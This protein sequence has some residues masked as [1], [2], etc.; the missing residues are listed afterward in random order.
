MHNQLTLR[1]FLI[2]S[3]G[4]LTLVGGCLKKDKLHLEGIREDLHLT[5]HQNIEAE[6]IKQ[7]PVLLPAESEQSTWANPGGGSG[8][9]YAHHRLNTPL[10]LKWKVKLDGNATESRSLTLPVTDGQ[11]LYALTGMGQVVKIMKTT[12]QKIW[13]KNISVDGTPLAT[14]GGGLCLS[15]EFILVSTAMGDALCLNKKTGEILW[16]RAL[17]APARGQPFCTGDKAFFLTVNNHLE[18][19]NIDTGTPLWAHAGIL[20]S[21]S[22]LGAGAVQLSRGNVIVPY[23]SGEVFSIDQESGQAQWVQSLSSITSL[24]EM[25]RLSQVKAQPI[26]DNQHIYLTSNGGIFMAVDKE[27]GYVVWQRDFGSAHTPAQ[28]MNVLFAITTDERLICVHKKT[29]K[30]KWIRP[31]AHPQAQLDDAPEDIETMN[32]STEKA[33]TL[34]WSSPM[35]AGGKLLV[36]S[37]DGTILFINPTTGR[38]KDTLKLPSALPIGGII[39]ENNLYVATQTG[40]L[41]A[42]AGTS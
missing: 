42:Y 16:R 11:Y 17:S 37:S 5:K 20:E 40:Q 13:T 25:Q 15:N 35:L 39:V 23:T 4:I 3:C 18:T 31:L 19:L 36:F 10:T 6:D 26:V 22:L 7:V 28:G 27:S 1:S 38:L 2:F 32:T 29:G 33:Q 30:V 14:L 12:G 41:F 24:N 34:T 8:V 21:T 9:T